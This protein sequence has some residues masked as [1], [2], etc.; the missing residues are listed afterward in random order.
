MFNSIELFAG[1]GG[2]A[3]GLEKAG[4]EHIGLIEIDVDA[5]NTLKKNRPKWNVINEDIEKISGLDLETY[6]KIGR[7]HV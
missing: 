5:A 3:L 4:F 2:L 6:F 1:A 7:A